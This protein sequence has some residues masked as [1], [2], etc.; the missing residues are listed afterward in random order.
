MR[1][2]EVMAVFIDGLVDRLTAMAVG[3]LL[4]WLLVSLAIILVQEWMH[5]RRHRREV[6]AE[7]EAFR[8]KL[9]AEAEA[10][11]RESVVEGTVGEGGS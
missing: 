3:V 10:F 1:T 5:V 6:A 11:R 8:R 9:L 7:T 4:G 2:E